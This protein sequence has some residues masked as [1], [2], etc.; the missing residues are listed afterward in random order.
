MV[1][2]YWVPDG[3]TLRA[4]LIENKVFC[5]R[6]WPNVLEWCTEADLEY[7]LAQNL[8][9]IPCD[10]RYGVEEMGRIVEMIKQ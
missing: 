9:A 2:P 6:Y 3:A 5:A 8:V 7:N 10:Q 1:Y 4:K